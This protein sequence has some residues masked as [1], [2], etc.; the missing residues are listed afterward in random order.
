MALGRGAVPGLGHANPV[1]GIISFD[2]IGH[3]FLTIF[4]AMTLE[5]WVDVMYVYQDCI[6][7]AASSIYWCLL[8]VFGALFVLNLA[9]AVI[10]DEYNNTQ[11]EADE[12]EAEE[13]AA[14]AAAIAAAV[15]VEKKQ[16]EEDE[17]AAGGAA[18]A[19]GPATDGARSA[20]QEQEDRL[21]AVFDAHGGG[22]AGAEAVLRVAYSRKMRAETPSQRFLE[23]YMVCPVPLKP[24]QQMLEAVATSS[25]L[26]IFITA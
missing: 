22:E 25:G 9:L 15:A 6:S 12:D 4:V 10:E 21:A 7:Y 11:E 14:R 13:D 8:V 18:S 1:A 23:E 19:D 16:L 3:A 24:L 5:G 17:K 2:D 20:G 26:N